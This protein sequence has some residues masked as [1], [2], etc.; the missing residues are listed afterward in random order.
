MAAEPDELLLVDCL[1]LWLSNVL[2]AYPEGTDDQIRRVY[3]L[4]Q[5]AAREEASRRFAANSETAANWNPHKMGGPFGLYE[6]EEQTFD[7]LSLGPWDAH[8]D[9]APLTPFCTPD[10]LP[11][12]Y[13]DYTKPRRKA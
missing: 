12:T 13:A 5:A 3:D 6:S 10:G 1:T 11:V 9:L 2:L 4:A 8:A 7:L